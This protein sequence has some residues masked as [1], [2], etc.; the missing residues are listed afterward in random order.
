MIFLTFHKLYYY[1][2]D[3]EN[4]FS[5][6]NTPASDATVSRVE[7]SPRGARTLTQMPSTATKA[8]NRASKCAGSCDID[9]DTIAYVCECAPQ[10]QHGIVRVVLRT[11]PHAR[12]RTRRCDLRNA[13]AEAYL[14]YSDPC[15]RQRATSGETL[16]SVRI[17][18]LSVISEWRQF[19]ATRPVN[20]I[21]SAPRQR[22]Q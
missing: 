14:F 9:E 13:P 19:M 7:G 3:Q 20:D 5:N 6:F 8:R 16:A 18:Y 4:K 2:C 12:G 21:T 22:Q 1:T 10:D 17:H 11:R 15:L